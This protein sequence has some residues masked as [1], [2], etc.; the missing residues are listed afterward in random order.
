MKLVV[1]LLASLT[2]HATQ[3]CEITNGAL[4]RY[5]DQVLQ[6]AAD[7]AKSKDSHQLL[8]I[9]EPLACMLEIQQKSEGE[10]KVFASNFLRPLLG[11]PQNPY[12]AKDPRYAI[13]A[14]ETHEDHPPHE[15][16]DRKLSGLCS[17]TWTV[18][19]LQIVLRARQCGVLRAYASRRQPNPT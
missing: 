5:E 18:G 12:A 7:F 4:M 19:L 15:G 11:G 3:V 6:A 8:R 13:V 14:N 2:L 1:L 10:L 17:R 16:F 9:T